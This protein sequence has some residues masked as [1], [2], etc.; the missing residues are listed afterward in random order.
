MASI[1]Q[2][3]HYEQRTDRRT[4]TAAVMFSALD[5]LARGLSIIPTTGKIPAFHLLPRD[6][7]GKPTWRPF[8]QRPPTQEEVIGWFRQDPDIGFAVVC[9]AVSG[10]LV[11][12]EDPRNG[13]NVT[14]K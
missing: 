11:L 4:D 8:Q 14:G 10:V 6:P 2:N 3:T 13:G 12:D 9:G 7:A 5:A 1:A